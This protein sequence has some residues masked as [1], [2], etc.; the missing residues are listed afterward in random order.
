M[1]T[2]SLN[3]AFSGP[4]AITPEALQLILEI[5]AR[6]HI[7]DFEAVAAKRA[8]RVDQA[9]TMTIRESG[10]AV[11]PVVGP[12]FRYANLFTEISGG[13]SVSALARDF[14]GALNDPSIKAILLNVD[15]PGGEVAG[16]SEFAQMVFDG[17]GKKRIAAY[18]DGMMASAA[19]WIASAAGEIIADA[20][21]IIGSIGIVAAVPNPEKRSARDVEFVSSQ[22]PRKRPNPNTESG[23]SQIQAMVD[24]LATV[25]VGAVAKHRAVS[26]AT[27]LEKFGQ[28]DVFVGK[29]A[30]AAGLADRLG[31]FEQLVSDLAAGRRACGPGATMA[32]ADLE[33][34][35]RRLRAQLAPLRQEPAKNA[36]IEAPSP[37]PMTDVRRRA[38]LGLTPRG[39]QVLES[40]RA[41]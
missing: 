33:A 11:I 24:D 36:I 30:V 31:S 3:H 40:E 8:R 10:V 32:L 25:F 21:A 28:G 5:A 27:V 13:T 26:T 7:P 37:A 22:S 18:A 17:R 2:R 12:I 19:Y 34:E 23:K 9:D 41:K 1:K 16:I 6:E 4:W 29:K 15:S 20:T 35:N 14:N 38:L 39:R